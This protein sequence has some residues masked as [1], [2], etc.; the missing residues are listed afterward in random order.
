MRRAFLARSFLM[1]LG[2]F[3]CAC[4]C[5]PGLGGN[6]VKGIGGGTPT[7]DV[8]DKTDYSACKGPPPPG[9]TIYQ[10]WQSLRQTPDGV[11]TESHLSFNQGL[12]SLE[13]QCTR[14]IDV[15]KASVQTP[16]EQS[17]MSLLLREA[18]RQTQDIHGI[19]C[20]AALQAGKYRFSFAGSCLN[21]NGPESR[22][23]A[24]LPA[25]FSEY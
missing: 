10:T 2:I 6:A 25:L 16:F 15:V 12:A 23:W 11:K 21:L 19:H 3:A 18:A 8:A 4:A 1:A 13:V 7:T 17:Q 20:V 22:T 5:A 14:G 9:T 24:R